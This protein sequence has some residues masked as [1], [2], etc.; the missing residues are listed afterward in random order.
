MGQSSNIGEVGVGSIRI[1]GQRVEDLPLGLGN[2]AK[3]QIPLALDR[4]RQQKIATVI[5]SFPTGKKVYYESR[6]KEASSNI[7][8][9]GEQ[10]VLRRKWIGEYRA[11]LQ[12]IEGMPNVRDLEEDIFA[13]SQR[14]DIDLEAKKQIIHDMKEGHT[15]YVAED[16]ITQMGQYETDI[17]RYD[18]AIQDENDSIGVLRQVIGLVVMR[19]HELKNLGVARV[20]V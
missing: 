15:T 13:I 12:E 20:A 8:N 6:I 5:S 1:A 11:T 19:D 9:F 4:E 2:E 16:M 7:V 3:G 14:S 17:E 10:R 18:T